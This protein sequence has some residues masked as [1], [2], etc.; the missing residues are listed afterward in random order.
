MLGATIASLGGPGRVLGC[1]HPVLN[2]EFVSVMGWYLHLNT[3]NIGYRPVVELRKPRP[4]VL[5]TSLPN[6]WGITPYHQTESA[7]AALKSLYVP[8]ARHPEGVLV[9]K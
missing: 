5:F 7:C 4:M 9:P 1:G 3:G 6:G 2:V 8:T